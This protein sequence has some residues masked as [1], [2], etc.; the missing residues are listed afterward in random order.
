MP[1]PI[2]LQLYTVRE[3]LAGDFEGVVREIAA[4][5]YAGVEPAGFPGTTPEAA[6]KLFRELG[7]EVPS[8]HV[9]LPLGEKKQ[10]ALD[11]MAALGAHR[12]VSGLGPDSF[13]SSD[14]VRAA[15]DTFNEAAAVAVENGL[16]FAIH[17]HWWEFGEVD[18][19]PAYRLM[20]ELLSKDVD[21]ELDVYWAQ[22]AGADPA[23]VIRELG[24]RVPLLHIKDGPCTRE[25]PMTAVGEGTVDFHRIVEAAGDAAEWMIVELDRCATDM[26]EAVKKSYD[27]LTREELARGRED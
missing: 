6:G 5:G 14:A 23:E 27:Y 3:A 18:G 10:E 20:L 12:I 1:A 13:A 22:T 25:D 17:N 21:F 7:L 26:M 4:V 9:P 24:D 16:G 2:A 8:A 11:I 19:R 15:C